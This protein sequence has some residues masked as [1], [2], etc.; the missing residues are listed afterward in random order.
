MAQ[1]YV[2]SRILSR[3]VASRAL[4]DAAEAAIKALTAGNPAGMKQYE[5]LAAQFLRVAGPEIAHELTGE[6]TAELRPAR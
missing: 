2:V 5:M 1:G 3:P 4:A 6:N